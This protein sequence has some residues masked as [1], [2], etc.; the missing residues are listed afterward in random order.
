MTPPCDRKTEVLVYHPHLLW[1]GSGEQVPPCPQFRAH[2][3]T[4][5]LELNVSYANIGNPKAT[6]MRVFNMGGP[7]QSPC[8]DFLLLRLPKKSL[9][10]FQ[11]MRDMLPYPESEVLYNSSPQ[12]SQH[13]GQVWGKTIFPQNEA[14]RWFWGD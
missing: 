9:L 6:V 1:G 11:D 2:E 8:S 14:G 5:D 13:Q 12:H 10:C 4:S 7:C 3:S